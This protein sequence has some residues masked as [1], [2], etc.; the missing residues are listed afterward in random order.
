MSVTGSV[1]SAVNF[2]VFTDSNASPV[3]EAGGLIDELR[4]WDDLRT[5]TEVSTN[6]EAELDMTAAPA[7]L[8]G[9]WKMNGVTSATLIATEKTNDAIAAS[10]ND[11]TCTGAGALTFV[12]MGTSSPVQKIN[13]FDAYVFDIF[14]QQENEQFQWNW[15]AV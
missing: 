4:I 14:G 8:V 11:L 7:N 12:D 13:S 15:K 6:Y 10:T 2:N 5:P 3:H 1:S 9:Y